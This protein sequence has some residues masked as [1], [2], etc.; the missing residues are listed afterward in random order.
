MLWQEANGVNNHWLV[1]YQLRRYVTRQLTAVRA[2]THSIA[3]LWSG[4]HI[5]AALVSNVDAGT[6]TEDLYSYLESSRWKLELFS[7][8]C[9]DHI[10]FSP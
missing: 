10:L 2:F 5:M 1:H 8:I 7:K 9:K 4:F 3:V 6:D